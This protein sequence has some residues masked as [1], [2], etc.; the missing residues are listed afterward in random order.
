MP[1][2]VGLIVDNSGSMGRKRKDV[3]AAVLTFVRSSN[4][5]DEMFVVNFNEHMSFG[6]PDTTLFSAGTQERDRALNG[7]P[8]TGKTATLDKKVLIVT[9]DGGDNA[10]QAGVDQV[11][12]M[13][14]RSDITIYTVGLFDED[15]HDRNPEILKKI[16]HATGGEAFLPNE[17]TEVVPICKRIAQ[18]I[19]NQ[20]TIGYVSTNR[21]LDDTYRTIRVT[22]NG[23][24]HERY[25]VRTRAGYIASS[26]R[27]ARPEPSEASPR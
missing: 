10:S 9:S 1:V 6:L 5:S 19:R 3:A 21:N 8:A 11:L 26:G 22:A 25:V 4:P 13:A 23:P 12:G 27:N 15:D 2:A 24:H 7:T 16:A 20:Y 18:D 14:G 17:A